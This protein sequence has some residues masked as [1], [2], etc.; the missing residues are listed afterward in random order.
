MHYQEFL[1]GGSDRYEITARLVDQLGQ[2]LLDPEIPPKNCYAFR[3][4]PELNTDHLAILCIE[5]TTNPMSR[6]SYHVG[7]NLRITDL[8]TGRLACS[9]P[10]LIR[11]AYEAESRYTSADDRPR[12]FTT[13]LPSQRRL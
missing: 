12:L 5:L 3:G 13:I 6:D 9:T 2:N 11:I 1:G 7:P 10:L 4:A 8:S